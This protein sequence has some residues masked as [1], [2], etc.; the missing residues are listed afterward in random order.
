VELEKGGV[1]F[2]PQIIEIFCRHMEAALDI[3]PQNINMS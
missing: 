1:G 3:I 2:N